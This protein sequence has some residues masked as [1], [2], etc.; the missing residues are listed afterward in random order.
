MEEA[1]KGVERAAKQLA[2]FDVELV[3]QG[4]VPPVVDRISQ[5]CGLPVITDC[6]R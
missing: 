3:Y 2:N 5:A 1:L 4:G 6:R